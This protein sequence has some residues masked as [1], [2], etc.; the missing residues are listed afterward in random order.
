MS[1]RSWRVRWNDLC[2]IEA[3]IWNHGNTYLYPK[4]LMSFCGLIIEDKWVVNDRIELEISKWTIFDTFHWI[5]ASE[6]ET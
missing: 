5:I 2:F 6:S 4:Y 1:E 3:G